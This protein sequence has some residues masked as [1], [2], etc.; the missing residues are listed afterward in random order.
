MKPNACN[1]FGKTQL[2]IL[3]E[4]NFPTR[5]ENSIFYPQKIM[6]FFQKERHANHK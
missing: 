5:T 1:R 2:G 4:E 3:L 6:F